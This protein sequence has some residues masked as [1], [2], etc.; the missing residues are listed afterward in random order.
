M[1]FP[2]CLCVL[3]NSHFPRR[4]QCTRQNILAGCRQANMRVSDLSKAASSAVVYGQPRLSASATTSCSNF[5]TSV[6]VLKAS[7]VGLSP[8]PK[9]KLLDY[10]DAR[11]VLEYHSR[12]SHEMKS[13]PY[14]K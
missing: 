4:S 13:F 5:T 9:S 7:R 12:T 2:A 8:S 11:N 10:S 14:G 3:I 6:L 1:F